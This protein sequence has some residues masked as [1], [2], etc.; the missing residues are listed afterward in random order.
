[1]TAVEILVTIWFAFCGLTLGRREQNKADKLRRIKAAARE[2][3]TQKGYEATCTREIAELAGVSVGTVFFY[4]RDKGELCCLMAL[5]R[6]EA[7]FVRAFKACDTSQPLL[8]QLMSVFGGMF[9]NSAR[10]IALSRILV[11]E[12]VSYEGRRRMDE[13]LVSRLSQLLTAA[14][15]S[16]EVTF[17][18]TPEFVARCIHHVYLAEMRDWVMS[19]TP[20]APEGVADLRRTLAL[21]LQG[22]SYQLRA[23]ARVANLRERQAC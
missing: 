2:L 13:W 4:A 16:G 6:L 23:R 9:K 1:L 17:D 5:D 11:K 21:V 19:E 12:M 20:R 10:N 8:D 7:G 22:L 3:F 14:R 18:E 15:E